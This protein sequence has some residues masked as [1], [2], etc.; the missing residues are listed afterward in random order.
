V[1]ED[2]DT[3]LYKSSVIQTECSKKVIV[4]TQ[5]EF[6]DKLYDI[7]IFEISMTK[8]FLDR[9]FVF[10]MFWVENPSV[11]F[12]CEFLSNSHS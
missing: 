11:I 1:S 10:E 8:N 7:R 4:N 9:K 12:K 3:L 2:P 6:S 5:K